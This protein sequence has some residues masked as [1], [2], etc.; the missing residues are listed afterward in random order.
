[1]ETPHVMHIARRVL[2]LVKTRGR[3]SEPTT[4]N[5]DY[6]ALSLPFSIL[7]RS[8]VDPKRMYKFETENS[9]VNMR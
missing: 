4:T 2:I 5:S 9:K 8:I 7:R 3:L 6:S 1:M